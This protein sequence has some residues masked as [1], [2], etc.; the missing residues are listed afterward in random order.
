MGACGL[1]ESSLGDSVVP[2]KAVW[3]NDEKLL[4]AIVSKGIGDMTR[5]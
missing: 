2:G 5:E 4:G 3:S 1:S